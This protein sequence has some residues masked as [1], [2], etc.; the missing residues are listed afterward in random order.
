MSTWSILS[1]V[2]AVN[3]VNT[4]N[5]VK[6]VAAA[7]RRGKQRQSSVRLRRTRG[8][9]TALTPLTALTV[10]T[11]DK[12]DEV[13]LI[14]FRRQ[15]CQRG[16]FCPPSMQSTLSTPSM[17]SKTWPPPGGGALSDQVG[18]HQC[19][20]MKKRS[21]LPDRMPTVNTLMNVI[22]V[23]IERQRDIE[24]LAWLSCLT[25]TEVFGDSIRSR[26]RQSFN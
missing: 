23:V 21:E 14:G 18:F 7:G 6:N 8:V 16:Q 20:N 2:N 5:A 3:L 9:W 19:N 1:A 25:S 24:A 26:W 22:V 4:V 12:I 11:A 17:P 10:L 13:D 15:Q